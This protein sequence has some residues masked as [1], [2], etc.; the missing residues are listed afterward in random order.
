MYLGFGRAEPSTQNIVLR[1]IHSSG[2][3]A[4]SFLSAMF[5]TYMFVPIV[6]TPTH[7]GMNWWNKHHSS[8]PMLLLKLLLLFE[9]PHCGG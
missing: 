6:S 2:D 7:L 1:C 8:S 5:V 9:H 3:A 4:P